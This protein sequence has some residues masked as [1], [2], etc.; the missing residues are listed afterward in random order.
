MGDYVT[1]L[2]RLWLYIQGTLLVVSSLLLILWVFPISRFILQVFG[3]SGQAFQGFIT[4]FAITMT[5][6]VL[7]ELHREVTRLRE[8]VQALQT[9]DR[10]RILPSGIGEIYP[11]IMECITDIKK[12]S[13]KSLTVL[14]LT[15]YTAWPNLKQWFNDESTRNWSV[16]MCCLNP[17]FLRTNHECF[18][19]EWIELANAQCHAI[20]GQL[21]HRSKDLTERRMKLELIKYNHFPAVHGFQLGNGAL[22]ISFIHWSK[23]GSF[24]D[25]PHQFYEYFAPSDKSLRAESFRGLFAN[26]EKK[27][28]GL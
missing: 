11:S 21:K 7:Y 1:V 24:L 9:P 13:E 28:R 6:V 12:D 2:R 15:L 5:V 23:H 16:S 10:G 17:D 22:F 8:D 3:L 19:Q 14:G 25:D 18:N 20:E 4:A 26:W 27:A